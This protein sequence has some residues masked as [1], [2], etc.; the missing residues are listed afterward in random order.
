ME[1]ATIPA[2]H[3]KAMDLFVH[4]DDQEKGVVSLTLIGRDGYDLYFGPDYAPQVQ[5]RLA[6]MLGEYKVFALEAY[7]TAMLKD[8][9]DRKGDLLRDQE[10]ALRA[11]TKNEE[12]IKDDLEDNEKMSKETQ[13]L[14]EEMEERSTRLD[15]LKQEITRTKAELPA[16]K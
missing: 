4:F 8:Q 3:D 7:Y 1:E 5:A 6:A 12:R 14:R 13:E 10:K 11:I 9:N 16:S 15:R 2:L